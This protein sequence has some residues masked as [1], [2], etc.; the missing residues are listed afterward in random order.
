MTRKPEIAVSVALIR[1][2]DVLLIERSKGQTLEGLLSLPGGR[3]GFGETLSAAAARE[4]MEEVGVRVEETELRFVTNHQAIYEAFH[5]VICVFT[6]KLPE[7]AS[8]IAGSD[9]ARVLFR[10]C[11][12]IAG[13]EASGET[14]PELGRIVADCAKLLR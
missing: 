2:G 8:P 3:V 14:T 10:P 7:N 6:G 12:E 5:F 4:I 11:S 13:L 9:A 1:D